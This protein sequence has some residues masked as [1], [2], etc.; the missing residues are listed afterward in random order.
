MKMPE[1]MRHPSVY[2]I[3]V[4]WNGKDVTLD[5]LASLRGVTYPAMKVLVVDNG[6]TDGSVA[7]IA[8]GFPEMEILSLNEN[9][10]FAGGNNAG[11]RRAL[12]AGADFVL[13]LNN[14]TVVDPGFVQ[15]LLD[16]FHHEDRCGMVVPKIFYHHPP[17]LLWYAGGEISFWTGTMRHR[18]IREKDRGQYDSPGETDYATG[19]CV[20]VSREV[21]G[22]VGAMDEGYFMYT[23]DADWSMRVRRAGYRVVFEPGA[24]LWHR[25]SVSTGGHLSRFKLKNKMFSNYRFFARYARWY[26]W[27]TFPWLSIIVNALA[28]LRYLTHV[29][30]R[31]PD[32]TA[33]PQISGP[34]E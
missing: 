24:F 6:S 7:A 9:R 33:G 16:R 27:L 18:G 15:P 23:E 19:C 13:L 1:G 2:V 34:S 21:I 20:L 28:G 31:S 25:L 4:N 3:V 11:I 22:R 26:H 29:V 10:R 30:M 14:D 12:E 17:D 5:C 32:A 8:G